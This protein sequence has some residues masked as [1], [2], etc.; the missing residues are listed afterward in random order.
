M[1]KRKYKDFVKFSTPGHY[2]GNDESYGDEAKLFKRLEH[3]RLKKAK[4]SHSAVINQGC[5]ANFDYQNM[6]GVGY[7]QRPK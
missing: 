3:E 2:A 1:K 4:L 5:Y 7:I 6:P